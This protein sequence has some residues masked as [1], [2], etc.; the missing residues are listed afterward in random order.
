MAA[1]KESGLKSYSALTKVKEL[2]KE[3]RIVK[4][5]YDY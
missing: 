1:Y 3:R 2:F 4:E 5:I